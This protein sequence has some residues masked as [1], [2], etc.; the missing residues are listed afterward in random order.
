MRSLEFSLEALVVQVARGLPKIEG[1]IMGAP[2]IRDYNILGVYFGVSPYF[3]QL[4]C[5]DLGSVK[6]YYPE[7]YP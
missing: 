7:P 4:P 3:R 2:I 1:T 6:A 5:K